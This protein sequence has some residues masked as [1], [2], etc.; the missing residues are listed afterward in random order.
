MLQSGTHLSQPP[1]AAASSAYVRVGVKRRERQTR[2][3]VRGADQDAA[4]AWARA[5]RGK[6]HGTGPT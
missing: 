3:M 6:W 5:G 2:E 4:P 1:A